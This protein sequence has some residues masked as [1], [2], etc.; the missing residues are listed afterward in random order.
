MTG[1][2]LAAGLVAGLALPGLLSGLLYEMA[3]TDPASFAGA[4]ALLLVVATAACLAPALR[5]LAI[6]PIRALRYE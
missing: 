5:A 4:A 3:P 1:A 2:G 6:Q